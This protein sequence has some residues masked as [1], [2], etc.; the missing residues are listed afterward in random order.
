MYHPKQGKAAEGGSQSH[1]GHVRRQNQPHGLF[2]CLH[3]SGQ[4]Y[5]HHLSLTQPVTVSAHDFLRKVVK[6]GMA[7]RCRPPK[8]LCA[9]VATGREHHGSA[10]THR[11][12]GNATSFTQIVHWSRP[13]VVTPWASCRTGWPSPEDLAAASQAIAALL[14]PA[15]RTASPPRW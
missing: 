8:H 11:G 5:G 4:K 15:P 10:S 1:T 14:Q 3:F 6:T 12:S 2:R 13:S 9:P 7:H